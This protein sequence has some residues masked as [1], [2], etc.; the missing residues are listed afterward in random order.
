MRHSVCIFCASSFRIP[1]QYGQVAKELGRLCAEKGITVVNGAGNTGLMG[2]CSD[3][4]LQHGG[5]VVGVIPQ[6]MIDR[7]WG[8]R[9]L[10]RLVITDDMAIRRHRMR[11]L[12]EGIIALPGGCGTLEELFETVTLKQ[13]GLYTHPIVLLNT[14]GYYDG[15]IAWWN[16][17][18]KE[19]FML[20]AHAELWSVARTPQEALDLFQ[21]IPERELPKETLKER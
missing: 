12:S 11:E 1:E 3:A 7:G 21:A 19:Q 6:F 13:M 9:G 10:T 2:L 20:P 5:Q 16:R 8:H 17:A 15:L 4:C 18:L 14:D